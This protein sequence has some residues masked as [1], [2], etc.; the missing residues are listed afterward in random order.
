MF[1]HAWLAIADVAS[2]HAP[3]MLLFDHQGEG[4]C[5]IEQL[6]KMSWKFALAGILAILVCATATAQEGHWQGRPIPKIAVLYGFAKV[7]DLPMLAEGPVKE[8]CN[9]YASPSASASA[10][11]TKLVTEHEEVKLAAGVT[12][13]LRKK[14]AKKMTVVLARQAD[15]PAAGSLVFTGCFVGADLSNADG[16]GLAGIDSGASHLSARVRV[17][18]VGRSGSVPVDEFDLAVRGPK[19]LADI[20]AIGLVFNAAIET[21]KM[22]QT[23]TNRLADDILKRLKKDHLFN[24]SMPE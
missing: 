14:L 16:E 22:L 15:I 18:Y 17:F 19:K 9:Y 13:E 5:S 21:L 12:K 1:W 8:T 24:T 23:D 20:G 4:R 7:S 6:I 10:I 11:E 2:S 3:K